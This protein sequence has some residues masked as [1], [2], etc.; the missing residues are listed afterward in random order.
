MADDFKYHIDHHASLVP[1]PELVDARAARLRDTLDDAGLRAVEEAAVIDGLRMQRRLGLTALSDGEFR[2]RNHLAVTYDAIAGFGATPQPGAALADLVGPLHAPEI[3][4]L[5]RSPAGGGRLTKYETD[6]LLASADRPTLVALASPGFLAELT[7][8]TVDVSASGAELAR[9]LRDE[10]AAMAADGIRYVLLRNPAYTFLL[11]EPGR[12]HARAL[13]IDPESTMDRMLEADAQVLSGLETPAE[14][15]VGL[16]I[17]TAGAASGGYDV[18]AV[19]RFGARLPFDRLCVE[20]PAELGRRFPLGELPPSTVVSLGIVDVSDP[21]LE[22]V[23]ELVGR[24]DDAATIVD[25]DNI[26]ISTNGGF[27]AARQ[28]PSAATQRAKL[29]LVEMV[30]RYFWGNEL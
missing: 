1:P 18:A 6:F 11:T 22:S 13:G 16:D 19:R 29:Q 15:R 9:I 4:Q 14:F 24:I 3:R 30:A 20:F 21:E 8:Q 10:I 27:H 12:E 17:T 23:E 25:I 2:R 7:T 26:A 28:P 5:D